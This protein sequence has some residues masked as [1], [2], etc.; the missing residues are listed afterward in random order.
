MKFSSPDHRVPNRK[1]HP[2]SIARANTMVR[3]LSKQPFTQHLKMSITT[4]SRKSLRRP[5]RHRSG[6]SLHH[7]PPR[8]PREGRRDRHSLLRRLPLRPAPGPQRVE[9]HR[10]SL[11]ARARDRRPGH[12]GRLRRYEI[13]GRRPRCRRL[14][15]RLLPQVSRLQ[16]R[17]GAVLRSRSCLHLQRRG[18]A[19]RRADLWGILR[20]RGRRR[21]FRAEGLR[22]ARSGRH[23]SASLRGHHHVLAAAP[24]ESRPAAR[25]S[26]SSVLADLGIWA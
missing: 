21:G 22:Q 20:A 24:L 13:Q 23:C 10:L 8:S 7:Q 1:T 14:H 3:S 11:R 2:S 17:H 25:R 9:Q 26:V 19:P 4:H 6:S 16:G 18:Q 5:E 15:G 12:Q